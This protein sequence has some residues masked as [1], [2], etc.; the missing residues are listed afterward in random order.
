MIGIF[1]QDSRVISISLDLLTVAL[2]LE[3]ARSFGTLTSFALKAAGDASFPAMV[4]VGVTWLVAVPLAL[5]LC[6]YTSAGMI[7]LWV[8]L[9]VDEGLRGLINYVRWNSG[10]WQ[11]KSVVA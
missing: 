11:G 3:A 5:Y 7:G 8:G 9:A 10:I 2:V 4:G 6:L 1:T